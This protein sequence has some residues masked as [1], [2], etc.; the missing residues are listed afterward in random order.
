MRACL[1]TD[2]LCAARV[3][4]QSSGAA[5]L[6]HRLIFEAHAAHKYTKHFGRPHPVWGSGSLM[7][8]ALAADMGRSD[9]VFDL[10]ALV[11]ISEALMQFRGNRKMI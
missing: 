11:S 4:S 1:I 5:T 7:A 6:A 2:L 10:A 8:R 3:V 9:G